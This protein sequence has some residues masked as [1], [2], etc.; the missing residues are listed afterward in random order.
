MPEKAAALL[1]QENSS[2]D[3]TQVRALVL[4]IKFDGTKAIL[5]TGTS[6]RTFVM[7]KD[8]D[9]IWDKAI[10]KYLSGKGIAFEELT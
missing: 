8:P 3:T 2:V 10:T 7:S 6:Y 5:T 1:A 4:N 9:I